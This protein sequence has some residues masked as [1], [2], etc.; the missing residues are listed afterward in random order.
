MKLLSCSHV[1]IINLLGSMI[2]NPGGAC[3][4]ITG[5]SLSLD[6]FT[7]WIHIKSVERA[8]ANEAIPFDDSLKDWS[9]QLG[10]SL[11]E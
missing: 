7:P 3:Y 4:V 10:N 11:Y 2:V 8:E 9:I 5:I 1:D 6:D